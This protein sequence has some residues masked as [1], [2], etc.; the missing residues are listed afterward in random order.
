MKNIN[1]GSRNSP[2]NEHWQGL[3]T[4]GTVFISVFTLGYL[5]RHLPLKT[6]D[7]I[8]YLSL[9]AFFPIS[10]FSQNIRSRFHLSSK[11][12]E[13][14][15]WLLT[16]GFWIIAAWI[17]STRSILLSMG[18]SF[19]QLTAEWLIKGTRKGL[20]YRF[21]SLSSMWVVAG[22][23]I[24]WPTDK[25]A[26]FILSGPFQTC[27]F[28]CL[29]FLFTYFG[30]CESF[31]Q[32]HPSSGQS[33][34]AGRRRGF[35]LF[36]LL[37]LVLPLS[38]YIDG[39][40]IAHHWSYFTGPAEL[41]RE[42]GWLL[43]DVPSQYGFLNIALI[44]AL[45]GAN[46]FQNLY[47]VVATFYLI[48]T[49]IFFQLWMR[50]FT[51]SVGR[52]LVFPVIFAFLFLCPGWDLK[53]SGTMAYPSVGPFRFI[54]S[55]TLLV[56]VFFIETKASKKG[57]STFHLVLANLL[58]IIGVLWSA[59]S[60]IY[61]SAVWLPACCLLLWNSESLSKT[62]I[63]RWLG[64]P[65]GI[66]LTAIGSIALFYITIKGITPD[67]KAFV[68]YPLAYA[69]G[70][71][72]LPVETKGAVWY[73]VGVFAL[74]LYLARSA[75]TQAELKHSR[76]TLVAC[77]FLFWTTSSYYASRS[78]QNNILNLLPIHLLCILLA[79]SA[80]PKALQNRWRSKFLMFLPALII[81]VTAVF[82]N[83]N[84]K[85][86]YAERVRYL[87]SGT[88]RQ[89]PLDG[90]SWAAEI[91]DLLKS[92]GLTHSEPIAFIWDHLLVYP[93]KPPHVQRFWIPVAPESQLG[94]LPESRQK[95]YFTRW[96]HSFP[97]NEGF[98]LSSKK[99]IWGSRVIPILIKLGYAPKQEWTHGEWMLQL[100]QK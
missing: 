49:V 76:A 45:P 21:L 34:T 81:P 38:S 3:E 62:N 28:G 9:L 54:F 7:T 72:S 22:Q 50:I 67:W 47:V 44:A 43:H 79:T 27:A 48:S 15:Q 74:L 83:P 36:T 5:L 98:V 11:W 37:L 59:E 88:F 14:L 84:F 69:H 80:L 30:L 86:V 55:E 64:L 29:F 82:C 23:I 2:S 57:I 35:T 13:I 53:L 4:I 100:F 16:S 18:L 17:G 78:H 33:I 65:L 93:D 24:Y 90:Y 77:L 85:N 91:D 20:V 66:F 63:L 71:G 42:G 75:L 25:F 1:K 87:S 26:E 70:F 61:C 32:K 97:R 40:S 58:W 52:A 41:V 95:V 73:L 89:G 60:A 12:R 68:E 31:L 8:I 39:G 6:R 96:L 56:A 92:A 94:I 51:S 46:S 19:L 10:L 99:L